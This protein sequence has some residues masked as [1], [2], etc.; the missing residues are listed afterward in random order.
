[1]NQLNI[2]QFNV[3][4]YTC[5]ELEGIIYKM[6]ERRGF[7]ESLKINKNRFKEYLKAVRANYFD[8]PYHNYHHATEVTQFIYKLDH[9]HFLEDKMNIEMRFCLMLAALNH[10]IAHPGKS[11]SYQKIL[12]TELYQRFGSN[13]TL[14][15]YH[16]EVALSLLNDPAFDILQGLEKAPLE[17]FIR[18]IIL[19]TDMK[20]H[21]EILDHLKKGKIKGPIKYGILAMKCA[22][23]GQLI[24]GKEVSE[25]WSMLLHKEQY[26]E[27]EDEIKKN[28]GG[29]ITEKDFFLEKIESQENFIKRY[30]YPLYVELDHTFPKLPSLRN[31]IYKP[32]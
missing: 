13:A 16:T 2:W 11:A 15:K 32:F 20:Q 9:D 22:D 29:S 27:K 7:L 8:N 25:K 6:F 19:S 24:R 10:D 4:K 5:D 18:Q 21:D 31:E 17:K 3:F 23:L 26:L 28:G 12:L 30:A 1:V 14:E